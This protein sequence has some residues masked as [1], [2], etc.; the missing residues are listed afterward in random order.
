MSLA[1]N[2][3]DFSSQWRERIEEWLQEEGW[4]VGHQA[5]Q[6]MRWVLTVRDAQGRP[7]VIAHIAEGKDRLLIEL[8]IRVGDDLQRQLGDMSA[9]ERR[10]LLFDMHEGLILIG[11]QWMDIQEPLRAFRI[12]ATC[13]FDGLDI[14]RT[15]SILRQDA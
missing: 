6:N 3:K 15:K 4:Q 13:H 1:G 11:V 12:A 9:H 2:E 7:L 10:N 14:T 5:A 8:G